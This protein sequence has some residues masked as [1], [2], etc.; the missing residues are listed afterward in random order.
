MALLVPQTPPYVLPWL[1][2]IGIIGIAHALPSIGGR[3]RL[4]SVPYLK[5]ASISI[6][7]IA[8]GVLI[9]IAMTGNNSVVT[10]GILCLYRLPVIISNQL[11]ADFVDRDGDQ[12]VGNQSILGTLPAKRVQ[13]IV[14]FLLG[15]S[16]VFGLVL[17]ML[18]GNYLLV[19][20]DVI[21]VLIMLVLCIRDRPVLRNI[22]FTLDLLVGWPLLTF[23]VS[24]LIQLQ[25]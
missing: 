21:G 4:K 3:R 19:S 7:W 11:V 25:S 6:A 18:T 23:L 9:P 15:T 16:V 1:A 14:I 22:S 17:A 5:T 13:F 12:S 10:I 8:G 2:A 20:V 24:W